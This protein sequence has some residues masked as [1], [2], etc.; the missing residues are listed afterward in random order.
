MTT[1]QISSQEIGLLREEIEMLMAERS[2]LLQVVGA[3]AVL[4][5]NLDPADL[6]S[7]QDVIDAAET[8]AEQLNALTAETLQEA[9]SSVHA[10]SDNCTLETGAS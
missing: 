6:P 5:A 1:Q 3:A 4:V 10:E 9:L 2:A 7:D 8:L